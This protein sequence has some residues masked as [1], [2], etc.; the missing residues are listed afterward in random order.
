MRF[1]SMLMVALF[2]SILALGQTN[3]GGISGTVVD[4]N[5]ASNIT[6]TETAAESYDPI[7]RYMFAGLTWK[8]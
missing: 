2:C 4:Q 7:G 1:I 3:R 6:G 8:L 5:G